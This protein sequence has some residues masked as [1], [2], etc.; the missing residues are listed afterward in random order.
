MFF[1]TPFGSVAWKLWN[2][3][4]GV[5]ASNVRACA[6]PQVTV[7]L[8]I[9]LYIHGGILI[10]LLLYCELSAFYV[11][12]WRHF[13]CSRAGMLMFQPM[14]C[15]SKPQVNR[16]HDWFSS[17]HAVQHTMRLWPILLLRGSLASLTPLMSNSRTCRLSCG[18]AMIL[19]LA[20]TL[21]LFTAESVR[22]VAIGDLM[23]FKS[24]T[25][26][27][28]SSLP[29]T[30]LSPTVNTADVTVLQ[31]K[32]TRMLHTDMKREQQHVILSL[33]CSNWN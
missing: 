21:I 33:L 30:T 25:L 17:F 28:R 26:T 8:C 29:E 11:R 19:W 13:S 2:R 32:D 15:R 22:M 20:E 5:N 31:Q 9:V 6:R 7:S 18:R 16:L 4:N 3:L 10:S 1:L 27:V 24:H 12:Q 14:A 23:F